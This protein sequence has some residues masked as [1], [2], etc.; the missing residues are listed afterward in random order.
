M[1][2]CA[3]AILLF[4]LTACSSSSARFHAGTPC[5][6]AEVFRVVVEEIVWPVEKTRG[7]T[8]I[9]ISS[10]TMGKESVASRTS[11]P[12]DLQEVLS[13]LEKRNA[14]QTTVAIAAS[15][16]P[17]ALLSAEVVKMIWSDDSLDGGEIRRRTFPTASGIYNFHL[18]GY[19][20]DGRRAV[21]HMVWAAGT[22]GIESTW[23]IL[24]QEHGQWRV[25]H[26]FNDQIS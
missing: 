7:S 16:T 13:S 17:L 9:L 25:E 19:S 15:R 22:L 8:V 11:V 12:V 20:A 2:R 26:H 24:K 14:Q 10:T 4:I 3:I 18:P 1:M 5:P 23:I 6:D 21:V